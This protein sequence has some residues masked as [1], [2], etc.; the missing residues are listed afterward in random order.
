MNQPASARSCVL[1]CLRRPAA[2]G[3]R[4]GVGSGKAP[5][6]SAAR[7]WLCSCRPPQA[8]AP[9]PAALATQ[10]A[11][12]VRLRTREPPGGAKHGQHSGEEH[13]QDVD[14]VDLQQGRVGE[15]RLASGSGQARRLRQRQRRRHA[16]GRGRAPPARAPAAPHILAGAGPP[17]SRGAPPRA[18]SWLEQLPGGGGGR[19][20]AATSRRRRRQRLA[21][22]QHARRTRD[23]G[24]WQV[25]QL[26]QGTKRCCEQQVRSVRLTCERWCAW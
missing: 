17:G 21:Q 25:A 23:P 24:N 16:T 20:S 5:A 26:L 12:T 22:R 11:A 9:W 8:R 19:R 7:G 18:S 14:K 15:G 2:M 10:Q 1:R 6:A 4:P 13:A 3:C